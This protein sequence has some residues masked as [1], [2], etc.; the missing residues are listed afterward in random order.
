[1]G[2]LALRGYRLRVP[3]FGSRQDAEDKRHRDVFKASPA[4]L[5]SPSNHP[6]SAPHFER[7]PFLFSLS[8][9]PLR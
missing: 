1:M 4:K 9:L 2:W 6:L 5:T 7:H 3:T 8:K